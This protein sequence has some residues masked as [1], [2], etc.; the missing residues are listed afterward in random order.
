VPGVHHAGHRDQRQEAA[1]GGL[2]VA[3]DAR[4]RSASGARRET[5][6][7]ARRRAGAQPSWRCGAP[8]AGPGRSRQPAG[9]SALPG[10]RAAWYI[11]EVG[12]AAV[13]PRETLPDRGR[14]APSRIASSTAGCWSWASISKARA[15]RAFRQHGLEHA[16][17]VHGGRGCRSAE[18]E[19]WTS[20]VR[21]DI[22]APQRPDRRRAMAPRGATRHGRAR[23][24]CGGQS[25]PGSPKL[26]RAP[27]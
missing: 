8:S 18:I 25:K 1:A 26:S 15:G 4:S 14:S 5:N 11:S 20:R 22:G 27:W 24:R 19:I 23:R 6:L 10:R 21:R 12:P 3:R 2:D 16:R 9:R 7:F 13:N 17:L